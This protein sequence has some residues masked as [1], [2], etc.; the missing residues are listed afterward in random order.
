MSFTNKGS[1]PGTAVYCADNALRRTKNLVILDIGASKAVSS[2]SRLLFLR[3]AVSFQWVGVAIGYLVLNRRQ[4]IFILMA[5]NPPLP[6]PIVII[7]NSEQLCRRF[8]ARWFGPSFSLP[9]EKPLLTATLKAG[10]YELL[11]P[12]M[13]RAPLA[14]IP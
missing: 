9:S 12:L 8:S 10:P 7:R 1:V 6:F 5:K 11:R 14:S 13:W 2:Q 3:L 4:L